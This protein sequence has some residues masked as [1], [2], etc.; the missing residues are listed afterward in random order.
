MQIKPKRLCQ[1]CVPC[2]LHACAKC[3][4][5]AGCIPVPCRLHACTLQAAYL[6]SLQKT[7]AEKVYL[8]LILTRTLA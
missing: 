8:D 2:R 5:P 6:V 7:G 4:Y 1:V 3:V